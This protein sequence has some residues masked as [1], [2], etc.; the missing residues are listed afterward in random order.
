MGR[1][2]TGVGAKKGD[3]LKKKSTTKKPTTTTT[4]T[5][6]KTKTATAKKE[7]NKVAG[8]TE[9]ATVE[10]VKIPVLVTISGL[11][12]AD[13]ALTP[14]EISGEET[15]SGSITVQSIE[16]LELAPQPTDPVEDTV[17]DV[18]K[19]SGES[20]SI[21]DNTTVS[22]EH[23][24]QQDDSPTD[25]MTTPT[26]DFYVENNTNAL[27]ETMDQQYLNTGFEENSKQEEPSQVNMEE[28][29]EEP[30]EDLPEEVASSTVT[31]PE[32]QLQ[33]L[34]HDEAPVEE[35]LGEEDDSQSTP[36]AL[37]MNQED[38][39]PSIGEP[40]PE[41][42]Y[43]NKQDDVNAAQQDEIEVTEIAIDQSE[44]ETSTVV[45]HEEVCEINRSEDVSG[46]TTMEQNASFT[47]IQH[48]EVCEEES[49]D[50]D[51]VEDLPE[52]QQQMTSPIHKVHFQDEQ[53]TAGSDTLETREEAT[54][55]EIMKFTEDDERM[56]SSP[57][58]SPIV[59]PEDA[60]SSET[61][62]TT[63]VS[64]IESMTFYQQ[65]QQMEEESSSK[66]TNKTGITIEAE[67]EDY[68]Y[69]IGF[70]STSNATTTTLGSKDHFLT[71]QDSADHDLYCVT[72]L[73]S[74]QYDS[75]TTFSDNDEFSPNASPTKSS[76]VGGNENPF[77]V[78]DEEEGEE[79]RDEESPEMPIAGKRC[80]R[81]FRC[82]DCYIMCTCI[83]FLN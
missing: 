53:D 75:E 16:T 66:T 9:N 35:S 69:K 22:Q 10:K 49:E 39:Q 47:L 61:M 77:S 5:D 4:N 23:Q 21:G 13:V 11:V 19:E 82:F 37:S 26:P 24:Q 29:E 54:S 3:D 58:S 65:Q 74:G 7:D 52:K 14:A 32:E 64:A 63:I 43:A 25:L 80:F 56:T 8:D 51:D 48:E 30:K 45:Q 42:D 79:T 15:A 2:A 81:L 60:I 62:Q 12:T 31:T 28:V 50:D 78:V 59:T 76:F 20:E 40:S 83:R 38:E 67:D 17:E 68:D 70:M 18:M 71:S 36:S 34:D 27:P 73:V 44:E 41:E 57:S 6:K 33:T 55:N 72:P 1:S 46:S